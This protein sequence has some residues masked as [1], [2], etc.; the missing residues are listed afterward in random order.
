MAMSGSG[1]KTDALANYGTNSANAAGAVNELN[2][3]YSQMATGDDGLT[4]QQKADALTASSQSTGGGVAS[5]VGQGGLLAARTG[6]AGGATAAID[7]AARTA[8]VTNSA[9]ALNVQN[10]SDAIARQ[11]QAT[12]L[13]GLNSIYDEANGQADASLNTANNT[14]PSFLQRLA[15]GAV[16]AAGMAAPTIGKAFH[17]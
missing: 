12:G 8:G 16:G 7:D 4:P 15:S 9:N 1:V 2:P 14:Q 3:I 17:I 10:Q 11:N 5:A 6:N 13:N